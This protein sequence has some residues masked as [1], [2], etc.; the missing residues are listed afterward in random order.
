MTAVTLHGVSARWGRETVLQDLD[1]VVPSGSWV[2]LIGPNGAGKSSLLKAVVGLVTTSGVV[3]F[4]GEQRKGSARSRTV[5]YLPQSP[6]F[7]VGMTVAEYVLLGRSAHLSWASSESGSDR[8]AAAAA[9]DR[10]ELS[11][12]ASRPV[13]ELSGGE[14]QRVALARALT[15][16]TPVLLLDEPTSALDL[17][18]QVAV[19]ELIDELRRERAL[20]VMSAMHDL[21][22]AGRFCDALVLLGEER[23]R[24]SGL[25]SDVLTESLLSTT[26]GA[27]VSLFTA[28]DGSL[29]VVPDRSTPKPRDRPS[30]ETPTN[31]STDRLL[32]RRT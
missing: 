31:Q 23:V 30:A 16:E 15:Q 6:V 32:H 19:L 10:L 5:A 13:T 4:D 25:P 12:L 29:V 22:A 11:T 27:G 9:I 20:T 2:G 24:A 17:G 7:P 8:S 18:H 14:A 3:A 1:L 28:S 26:Y 21:T